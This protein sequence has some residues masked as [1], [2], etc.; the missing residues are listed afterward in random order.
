MKKVYFLFLMIIASQISAKVDTATFAGG[1]FWCMEPPF[2][3]IDGIFEVLSGYTGGTKQDPS[4]KDVSTGKT[5]H[6]EAVRILFDSSKISYDSLL[7][8]FWRNIDPTDAFGQFADKGK[9]YETAIFY[10]NI[11]QKKAAELSK[12]KLI[13]SGVFKKPIVTKIRPA[14]VFYPAEQYHQNYAVKNPLRYT[15]YKNGSGRTPF[16]KLHWS[17]GMEPNKKPFN[18]NKLT[19]LE[20]H[21]TQECGTEPP[22]RN[23]YW[24]NKKEG[25]YVDK[26]SGEPL[27]SSMDKFDSGSGWPSFTT[28]I[29]T[30]M[31]FEKVDTAHG[32][33][34]TE[35]RSKSSD[36]HLG[37]VF[38]DGPE[39]KGLRY[40]I[41]SASLRFI[42]KEKM[43]EEGYE[44]YLSI[45]NR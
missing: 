2:K 41:N 12:N 21:V 5:G 36:S 34:R 43:Q 13:K 26:I 32:M 1:C 11:K 33:V 7:T 30:D 42:P 28:P 25:I 15:M 20:Y 31:I 9:Q 35:V 8:T 16:L 45:F 23:E 19:P 4:Y 37:H 3:K 10:H 17:N 39:P 6:V 18:K 24:N 44:V 40:C 29:K 22:F 27:F 38:P 14:S